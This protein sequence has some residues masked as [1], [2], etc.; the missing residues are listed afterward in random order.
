[1]ECI[2]CGSRIEEGVCSYCNTKKFFNYNCNNRNQHNMVLT[3]S[4]V[5]EN[6]E[7]EFFCEED[8]V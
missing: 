6:Y 5:R 3:I 1:M 2:N 8:H 7:L 4:E